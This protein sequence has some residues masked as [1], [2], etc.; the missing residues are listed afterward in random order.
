[1]I[2]QDRIHLAADVILVVIAMTFLGFSVVDRRS[3]NTSRIPAVKEAPASWRDEI[4]TGIRI[5]PAG[6]PVTI[7]E[8]MDFDCPVCAKWASRVDS[9]L[10]ESPGEVQ[11]VVHHFLEHA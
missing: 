2:G 10:I 8:F 3:A 7:I 9:L 11:L 5:G 1:M 6:A 4:Q